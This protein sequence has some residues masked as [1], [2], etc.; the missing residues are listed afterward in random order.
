MKRAA[1]FAVS[2]LR[3]TG[4]ASD[5]VTAMVILAWL[6]RHPDVTKHHPLKESG[7]VWWSNNTPVEMMWM[8]SSTARVSPINTVTP[9]VR[10]L[11]T[12]VRSEVSVLPH[13]EY[14]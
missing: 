13:W 2:V 6:R 14:V 11:P 12:Q 1:S 10:G 3:G 8:L 4:I 5:I 7:D 9:A